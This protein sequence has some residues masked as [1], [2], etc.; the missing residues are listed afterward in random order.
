MYPQR[1]PTSAICNAIANSRD[2]AA[3][4]SVWSSSDESALIGSVPTIRFGAGPRL[5]PAGW[6]A[7]HYPREAETQQLQEELHSGVASEQVAEESNVT[8][9]S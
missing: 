9:A 8:S 5:I 3:Q 2:P 7:I 1:A 4:P 6:I